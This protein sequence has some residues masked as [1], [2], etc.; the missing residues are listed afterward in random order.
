MGNLCGP[1]FRGSADTSDLITPDAVR[2]NLMFLKLKIDDFCD[3]LEV[4][5]FVLVNFE[6]WGL[7]RIL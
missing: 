7:V 3:L 5:F 1:C 2:K 4:K 6:I